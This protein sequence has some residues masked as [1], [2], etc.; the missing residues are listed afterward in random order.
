MTSTAGSGSSSG[1]TGSV[2]IT[3]SLP[4]RIDTR[5]VVKLGLDN[6][7]QWKLQLKIILKAA[8]I[9]DYVSGTIPKPDATAAA[10]DIRAWEDKDYLAQAAL[11]PTLDATNTRRIYSLETSKEMWEKLASIYS[12]SSVLNR[13]HLTTSFLNYKAKKNATPI[14]IYTDLEAMARHLNELGVVTDEAW[15]ISRIVHALPDEQH[16]A[17]KKAWASVPTA[18]QSM[19]HLLSRLRTEQLESKL[20]TM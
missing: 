5:N 11:V 15:T 1:G 18:D 3:V 14:E 7:E 8:K 2:P 12:D 6:Y 16:Y 9:W 20:T 13:Q 4:S 10:A 17:F 19:V